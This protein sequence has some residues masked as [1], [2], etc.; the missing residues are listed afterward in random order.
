MNSLQTLPPQVLIPGTSARAVGSVMAMVLFVII[1]IMMVYALRHAVFTL[2]R[3]LC[4]QRHP[5][6]FAISS[7]VASMAV[8]RDVLTVRHWLNQKTGVLLS[9]EQYTNP[10][11]RLL[12]WGQSYRFELWQTYILVWVK[13][14]DISLVASTGK[15][16]A[17]KLGLMW[18]VESPVD[19]L[20]SGRTMPILHICFGTLFDILIF[21]ALYSWAASNAPAQATS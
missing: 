16:V 19:D 7:S 15:A 2:R 1:L 17:R 4:R 8:G 6:Q 20:P 10:S 9:V 3:L 5:H 11:C 14:L 12:W 13:Q 18:Q 21:V